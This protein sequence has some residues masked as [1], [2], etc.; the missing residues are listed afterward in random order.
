MIRKNDPMRRYYIYFFICEGLAVSG[1]LCQFV[2][3]LTAGRPNYFNLG[4]SVFLLLLLTFAFFAFR[5]RHQRTERRRQL[6]FSGDETLL[7]RPQPQPDADALALPAKIVLRMDIG[8]LAILM[9]IF[10]VL[11]TIV[12]VPFALIMFASS[13]DIRIIVILLGIFFAIYLFVFLITF[14]LVALLMRRFM[15][16]EVIVDDYGIGSSMFGK[17]IYIPWPEIQSFAMWGNAKRFATIAFEVTGNDGSVV[18]WN[19]LGPKG[20]FIT[21]ISALKPEGMSFDEYRD[22][23]LRL[24]QVVVARSGKPLYDLRDEKITWW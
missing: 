3:S 17:K 16:Q 9:L 1:L 6:A 21:S 15:Y 22:R 8:K 20:T 5:R 10:V 13:R 11:L 7:A 24:Q 18:R 19:Q 4:M 14:V 2:S 23:S 12:V